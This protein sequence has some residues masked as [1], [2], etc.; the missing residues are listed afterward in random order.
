MGILIMNEYTKHSEAEVREMLQ[1]INDNLLVAPYG[2]IKIDETI[3]LMLFMRTLEQEGRHKITNGE[4]RRDTGMTVEGLKRATDA[5]LIAFK[6]IDAGKAI[7][8]I[9]E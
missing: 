2:L 6:L 7:D 3:G 4:I 5:L 8:M 1:R 9:L